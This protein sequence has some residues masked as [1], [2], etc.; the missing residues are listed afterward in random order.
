MNSEENLEILMETKLRDSLKW[1]MLFFIFNYINH[2]LNTENKHK[3]PSENISNKFFKNW[4]KH[5]CEN[6]I[7][8]D[9]ATINSILNSPKNIFYSILKNSGDTIEST[10]LYQEKY[11]QI[12]KKVEDF[13]LHNISQPPNIN[14]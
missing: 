11:N 7:N 4:K 1:S 5:T 8:K 14:E 10:E 12:L 2:Q 3:D 9:L 6:L 13:Y